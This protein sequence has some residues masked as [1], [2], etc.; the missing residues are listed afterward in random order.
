MGNNAKS[1]AGLINKQNHEILTSVHP[2]PLSANRGFFG[3]EIFKKTNL[4]LLEFQQEPISWS[5][6]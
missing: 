2:S 5:L 1:K 4:A 6:A 3:C